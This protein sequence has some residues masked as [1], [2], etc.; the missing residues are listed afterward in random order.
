MFE[1][2]ELGHKVDKET[3][4]REVPKLR[5]ELLDVQYDM[6][7][8]KEFP[9]VILISGVDGSGKG[10]TINLLYSWMDP[11]HISTLAFSAPSDEETSRPYMWRYWRALPPK[12][13]VGI[14]AGSWY[15]QPSPTASTAICGVP[16]SMGGWRISTVSRPCWSTKGRWS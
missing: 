6:L 12:G 16:I 11:R 1:S 3:F 15:S 5:A 7:E 9:V 2:A 13:K 8:K 4:K 14:F 10:E